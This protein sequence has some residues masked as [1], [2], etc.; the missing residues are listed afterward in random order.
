LSS[1]RKHARINHL[2]AKAKTGKYDWKALKAMALAIPVSEPTAKKYMDEVRARL[3]KEG[4]I[5]E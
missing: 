3:I 4:L 5:T 2:H 1:F